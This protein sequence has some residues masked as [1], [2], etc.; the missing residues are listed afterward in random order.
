MP[1]AAFCSLSV[2]N[3]GVVLE[4]GASLGGF[5]VEG[6]GLVSAGEAVTVGSG[7]MA[8]GVAVSGSDLMLTAA[9]E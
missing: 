8:A 2:R 9:A 7:C 1:C 6:F 5:W 4:G 3:T